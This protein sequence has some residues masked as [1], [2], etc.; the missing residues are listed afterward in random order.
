MNKRMKNS[1]TEMEIVLKKFDF[2]ND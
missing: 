1:I 2:I